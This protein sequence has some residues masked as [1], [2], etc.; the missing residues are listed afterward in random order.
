MQKG[1][2]RLRMSFISHLGTGSSWHVLVGAEPINVST[3]VLSVA[4]C[5]LDLNFVVDSSG[6]IEYAGVGNWQKAKDFIANIIRQLI[7]GPNNVQVAMVLFSTTATWRDLT[8]YQ[9]QAS[10]IA[11]VNVLPYIGLKTNL[12]DALYL[13]RTQVFAAGRGTR[14]NATKVT[15]ILTDGED[16]VPAKG[17]PL[18][19]QNATAC[20]DAGIRM[21]AVGV[22]SA[23]DQARLL[24]IVSSPSDYHPAHDFDGLTSVVAQLTPQGIC[25]APGTDISEYFTLLLSYCSC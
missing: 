15:V 16:D 20:K 5:V 1:D 14:A 12:N 18:T 7:I 2:S 19:I 24:Q 8:R 13:T 9:D 3:V 11:A 10:L 23:V 22:S 4:E 25:F 21:I 17:T 6:S